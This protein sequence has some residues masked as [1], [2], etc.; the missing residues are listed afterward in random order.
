[1]LREVRLAFRQAWGGYDASPYTLES[2]RMIVLAKK[3]DT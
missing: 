3:A 1:M 2:R